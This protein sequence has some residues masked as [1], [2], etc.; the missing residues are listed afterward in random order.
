[1]DDARRV[2]DTLVPEEA[3]IQGADGEW[4][5]V[6]ILPYRTTDDRIEGVVVTFV[7]VTEL[8]QARDEARRR[9]AQ[10]AAIAEIGRMALTA[11][12]TDVLEAAC[13]TAR[14]VLEADFA[15]VLRHEPAEDRFALDAGCGWHP[16][17]VGTAAVPDSVDSQG[18]FT[19]AEDGPV[20]VPD[21]EAEERFSGPELLTTHG[22][23]SGISITVPGDG[24]AWGV[25]GIHS[26]QPRTF[27][28]ADVEF[29][30]ALANLI[31]EA[32][33]HEQAEQ[34]IRQQLGEIEAVYGTAPV[35][36]AFMDRE[37]RYRRI[38]QRL[39][40]INGLPVEDHIGKRGKD[41]FPLLVDT[42][43][44]LLERVLETGEPIED[45]EF[46]G[47]T[48]RDPDLERDWLCSYVPEF[49]PEG[50]IEGVSIVVRDITDLRESERRATAMA[51]QLQLTLDA[52]R[53]GTFRYVV[54]DGRVELDERFQE[55]FG[56]PSEMTLE[57]GVGR[58][59]PGQQEMT[60]AALSRA[61][62]P[63]DSN[64]EYDIENLVEGDDG[65]KWVSVRA[66]AVF[67]GEGPDR[68]PREL[69]GV[70]L[71]VT[72]LRRTTDE[73]RVLTEDL[74][75]RVESRTA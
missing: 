58:V 41:L 33:R 44:P 36:L 62:D 71:D 48:L 47:A 73:L 25:L 72:D 68:T 26:R 51:E 8:R 19:L 28:A 42:V 38:N 66:R 46:R 29:V 40:D 15:K 6:R 57:A 67:D 31:G 61:L 39:A 5:F 27:S 22:V 2:L 4:Y 53:L 1:D 65:P 74:E 54:E 70:A 34:T 3:E 14:D 52:A 59:T 64:D 12:L 63:A 21:L 24:E 50:V 23:R 20:V 60:R 75:G 11:P 32:V 17:L 7:D 9:A 49:D 69:F 35:G 43:Q 37:L 55:L 13:E 30:G 18:G 56:Y 10:Q 16:G 45:I